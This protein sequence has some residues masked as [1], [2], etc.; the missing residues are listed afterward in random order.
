MT[1]SLIIT[2]GSRG[3]GAA[4][5]ILAAERGVDVCISYRSNEDAAREVVAAC[6]SA[7]SRAIAVCGD[8]SVEADVVALFDRAEVDVGPVT[9]LVNN[10]GILHTQA[11]LDEFTAERLH[12]VVAVNVVGA[13]LCAREAVRRLSTAH[14]GPG[15]VIVNV[16][17]AASYLG[18]PNE[19]IDYAA[20]KGA[21]DTMT[22]GLAKEVATEGI[23][24][25][26]VRPGLIETDIH[27]SSGEPGRVARLAPAVPMARGGT[28]DEVAEAILWLASDA[29]SY[30]T[31]SF[32]NVSGGR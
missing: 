31:G 16:S 6:E 1:G 32:I 27:A 13:F 3:I 18:S 15:G 22:I 28:A 7:G 8:V 12:E 19:F 21:V 17:S 25:N 10:A 14:G 30:V 11:R 24:V 5:A 9:G 23:R 4:T 2:G 26:A 29:S 20:T